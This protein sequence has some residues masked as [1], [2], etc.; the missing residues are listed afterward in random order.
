[1][2]G[3]RYPTGILKPMRSKPVTGEVYH[4][5]NRG[6]EKRDVFMDDNDRSRF[7][8][9]LSVFNDTELNFAA[10]RLL[11]IGYPTQQLCAQT[12]NP[13]VE[14]MAFCLMPNHYHLMLQAVTE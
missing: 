6:V 13:L 8:A 3:I 10:Y 4:I 2:L 9:A 5:F 14:I 12:R 1:M 11:G 7:L